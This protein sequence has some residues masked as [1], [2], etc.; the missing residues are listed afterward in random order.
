[1][2]AV[3]IAVLV[4]ALTGEVVFLSYQRLTGGPTDPLTNVQPGSKDLIEPVQKITDV[5]LEKFSSADEVKAFLSSM[6]SSSPGY[7]RNSAM[8][9]MNEESITVGMA[10]AADMVSAAEGGGGSGERVSTTNVQVMGID[11]P[12]YVKTD[13][14]NI[15][16]AGE[17][18]SYRPMMKATETMIDYNPGYSSEVKIFNALPPTDIKQSSAI[19][20]YGEML[21][22]NNTLLIFGYDK[23]VG[24][25]VSDPVKP[26]EKWTIKYNENNHYSTARLYGDQVYLITQNYLN[27]GSPC[28]YAPIKRG[29]VDVMISCSDIYHPSVAGDLDVT[30]SLFIL[31]PTD[32]QIQKQVSVMGSSS[33]S[34]IYMSPNNLYLTYYYSESLVPFTVAFFRENTDL[35]PA[36]LNDKLAKLVDYDISRGAKE[37]EMNNLIDK[38]LSSLSNDERLR[39]STEMS[40]RSEA[41]MKAHLRELDRTVISQFDN[42][43][44]EVKN[45][46]SVPGN[47]LNQFSLDE[48]ENNLRLVTTIGQTIGSSATQNDLYVLN[49]RMSVVGSVK[50]LGTGERVYSARFLSDKAYVVTFRQTDPFYVID[51]RD[52]EA[53]VKRGELK[54]PGYSSYLHPITKDKILGVGMEDGKVKLSLFDVANPADPQEISKYSLDEYWTEVNNNHRAFLQDEKHQVFFIPGSQGAYII[55]YKGDKLSLVKSVSKLQAKRALFIDDY[56]YVIT[57]AGITILNEQDW[58]TVQQL[59]FE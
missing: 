12:D 39:V 14:K 7:Y 2:F 9:E 46:A 50:D 31:N 3:I 41:F 36:W 27:F 18:Y 57:D 16:Y 1:M 32:G 10:P 19:D 5:T 25:D 35:F 37:V 17:S 49:K 28:P 34:V 48:Y 47:L 45:T 23:L 24:Y 21:L 53:P 56:L 42:K 59:D 15:F 30:Y 29:D 40:N 8:K 11:E 33:A 4:L 38:Y 6:E 54:I 20:N 58:S 55:S 51:L 44:L 43:T 26:T 52:P 13:G 22:K